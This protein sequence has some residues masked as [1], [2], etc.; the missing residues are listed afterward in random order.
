MQ[1]ALRADLPIYGRVLALMIMPSPATV[2]H[3]N[4]CSPIPKVEYQ[5][6]L[7][8]DLPPRPSPYTQEEVAD[9]VTSLSPGIQLAECR[10]IHDDSFPPLPVILADGAGSGAIVFGSAIEDW[11]NKD[12][13]GQEVILYCNGEPRRTGTAAAALD[14]PIVPL[15]W[16]ANELSRTGVGP[17]TGQTISTGTLTGMLR[18]KVGDIYV[19]DFGPFGT[20]TATYI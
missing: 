8:S 13:S 14:H 17:K 6:V 20:V 7:G 2:E 15:T 10:F 18:P 9:A 5:A 19:A 12:I 11:H 4:L 3:A 16:L 1:E